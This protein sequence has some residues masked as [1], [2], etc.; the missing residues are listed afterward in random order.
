MQTEFQIISGTTTRKL[1]VDISTLVV[2]GWA[3]RDR[4]AIEH[5]IE[6]LAAIG[7]P[8]PSNVPLYYRIANN[9]LTQSDTVQMVGPDSS[10]EIETFVFSADGELYVSIASDH[11]DRK[12]ES[13]SVALSK[14]LCAKPAGRSAWL[15]ADVEGHWDELMIRAWIEENGE[16]VLYQEGPLSTLRTPRDLINGYLAGS[17]HSRLPDGTGMTCGTV[18]AIG[19]IRPSTVFEMELHDPRRNLSLTHLYTVEVLPEVA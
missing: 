7:V 11:T 5:H 4:E 17:A 16:R 12:L 2:A 10:G 3:G 8:R 6:E 14:Q 9:Q 1:S 13:H 18:G 15:Y 19:G